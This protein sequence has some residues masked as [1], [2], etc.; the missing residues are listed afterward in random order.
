MT[1][2]NTTTKK[3]AADAYAAHD[4]DIARLIDV[5][6]M[7]LAAHANKKGDGTKSWGMVADLGKIRDD[8]INLVEFMSGMDRNAIEEFLNDANACD[9]QR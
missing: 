1:S 8:L 5:L 2:T 4:T 3:T 9:E 7:E 6:G